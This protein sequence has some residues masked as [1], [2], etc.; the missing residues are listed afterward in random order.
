MHPF[1]LAIPVNDLD[2]CVDFY[3]EIFP[4]SFGRSDSTWIDLN[5]YGHQLVLHLSNKLS[6]ENYNHVDGDDVPYPHFGI[7][8]GISDFLEIK[9]NIEKSDYDF[10]IKPK[11]RFENMPGEQHTMFIKDP[12]NNFIEIKAFADQNKLF[13]T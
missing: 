11:V 12:S 13:E 6:E 3:K 2:T 1:H 5:F 9:H 10:F 8:L 4:V 7:V